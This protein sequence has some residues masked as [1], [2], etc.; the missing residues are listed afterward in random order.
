MIRHD[1]DRGQRGISLLVVLV[2]LLIMTL[3]TASIVHRMQ[4]LVEMSGRDGLTGLPNRM[5]LLQQMPRL[6]ERLHGGGSLTLALLDLDRFRRVNDELGRI[7]GDRA[8][9]HVV[10]TLGQGLHEGER[11]VRMSGDEFVAL[12]HCPMGT[13]W[14]RIEQMRR[15]LWEA[16]F[17][18]GRGVDPQR[19]SFS[20]GLA[21]WPQDG[22][23]L[24]VLL[25][26]ADRRQR[27]SKRQGGNRVM[28]RD[29]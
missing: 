22:D 10:A 4:R 28:A 20:A 25:A 27:A 8:L 9:R 3:L 19:L 26:V 14:E 6:L 11:L 12:L 13:A 21:A 16:P 17:Q 29:P 7:D 24:S 1:F 23:D 15:L 2:L 5:W 18:P